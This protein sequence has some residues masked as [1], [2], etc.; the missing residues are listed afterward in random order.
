MNLSFPLP[1]EGETVKQAA[2]SSGL[3]GAVRYAN[4]HLNRCLQC[5]FWSLSSSRLRAGTKV[6]LWP[7][8]G[9]NQQIS[10]WLA[11]GDL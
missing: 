9:G 5:S 11:P 2:R 10:I 4:A 6:R 1:S 8:M 7:A 3:V